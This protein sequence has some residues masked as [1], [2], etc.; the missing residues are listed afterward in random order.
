[1]S[2]TVGVLF[3]F[4]V[5]LYIIDCVMSVRANHLLFISHF[6]TRF[7]L[8][9]T[10]LHLFGLLPTSETVVSPHLSVCLSNLGLFFLADE[11]RARIA[12]YAADHFRFIAYQD[13]ALVKAEGKSLIIDHQVIF[14]APS[15]GIAQEIARNVE[16]L[17][18]LQPSERSDR[19]QKVLSGSTSLKAMQAKKKR[20]SFALLYL[21][22]LSSILFVNVFMILPL[23]A[24]WPQYWPINMDRVLLVIG[25]NFLLIIG[26][27]IHIQRHII[28]ANIGQIAATLLPTILSPVTAIHIA[29][30]L[31][32]D[33]YIHFDHLTLAAAL[34]PSV[35]FRALVREDL[36]RL[37]LVAGA[38]DG[39]GGFAEYRGHVP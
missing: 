32:R 36:Q 39:C 30:N 11:N 33:L 37:A 3:P 8:K 9:R 28:G 23:A 18:A 25:L 4:V 12:L 10:G 15:A 27:A 2:H 21:K 7:G 20:Y 6:G 38:E 31:T 26:T 24:Y 29:N 16:D 19:I 14:R 17:K 22:T 5:L 34:L 35:E 1:M 13:I